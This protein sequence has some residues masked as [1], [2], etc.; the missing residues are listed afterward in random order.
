[1]KFIS[2]VLLLTWTPWLIL[3]VTGN[4][5]QLLSLKILIG[6]G[7]LATTIVT[8]FLL[9]DYHIKRFVKDYIKRAVSIG[10]AK[11]RAS[12]FILF[13]VFSV[14]LSIPLSVI[15]MEDKWGQLVPNIPFEDLLPFAFFVL[16]FGP[17]PEEL[18]WRGY[19]LD[20]L[21]EKLNP[22]Y[23]S[24]LIGLIWAV[25]H[26]PLFFI[27]GYPLKEMADSKLFLMVYFGSLFPKSI[28]M[29]FIYYKTNRNILTAILFH[30]FV[31]FMGMYL[32]ISLKTEV[33]QCMI[34]IFAG[35]IIL[36]SNPWLFI[37]SSKN[38]NLQ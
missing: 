33:I 24:L 18:G 38:E 6:L 20:G 17:V 3:V 12:L 15:L 4:H 35:V 26:I 7:G 25:W 37:N 10:F 34:F 13:P 32:D 8:I 27:E 30:F 21:S 36:I 16:V 1:L 11:Y 9:K 28:I 19:L 14:I 2:W 31:N 22:M 23:G 29:T 5:L